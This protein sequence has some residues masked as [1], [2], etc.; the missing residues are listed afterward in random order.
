[1]IKRDFYLNQIVRHMH[2]GENFRWVVGTY[3]DAKKD[4]NWCLSE[5]DMECLIEESSK[6]KLPEA[7]GVLLD[8][9][10]RLYPA[11]K[12]KFEFDF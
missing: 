10:R 7:S 1:M 3:G 11:K 6:R 8:L 2:N 4:D 5:A 12:K 9:K